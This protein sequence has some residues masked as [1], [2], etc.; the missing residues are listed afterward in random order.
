[1]REKI[2]LVS[3]SIASGFMPY[4]YC[5]IGIGLWIHGT[6]IDMIAIGIEQLA[7][8][9]HPVIPSWN[10]SGCAS[11]ALTVKVIGSAFIVFICS[12][13]SSFVQMPYRGVIG[14]P[15]TRGI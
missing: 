3:I 14:I 13:C 8:C 9:H 10:I 6:D 5:K 15:H 1:M 2:S 11:T 4:R 12:T 7:A